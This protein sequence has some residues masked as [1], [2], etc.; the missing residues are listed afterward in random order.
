MT[1]TNAIDWFQMFFAIGIDIGIE[2]IGINF[3]FD[4]DIDPDVFSAK[5]HLNS[6]RLELWVRFFKY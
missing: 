4:P 2:H 1:L 3:V 6:A 5:N